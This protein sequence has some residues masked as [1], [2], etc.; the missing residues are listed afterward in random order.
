MDQDVVALLRSIHS[1]VERIAR[2]LADDRGAGQRTAVA[3]QA[4]TRQEAAQILRASVW[5][6]DRARKA[7][8]LEESEQI[9]ARHIR[10]TG[11]SLL[12]LQAQRQ[13]AGISVKKM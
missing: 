12:R 1:D 9:S 8:L 7:G 5:T 6:V 11:Q 4:Y 2:A 10:I 13:R 3:S